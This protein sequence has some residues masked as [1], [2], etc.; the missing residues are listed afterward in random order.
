MAVSTTPSQVAT[1]SSPY[2]KEIAEN[3]PYY[4]SKIIAEEKA[5]AFA[6]ENDLDLICMRPTLLLGPGDA[7]VVL[8]LNLKSSLN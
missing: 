6:K 5:I 3:W 7:V 4:D 1:D 2:A 8:S